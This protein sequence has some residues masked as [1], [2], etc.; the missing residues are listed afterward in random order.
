MP[1]SPPRNAWNCAMSVPAM[2]ALPPAPRN[3]AARSPS[4]LRIRAQA[5]P[6]CSY[7]RHV[8]ALRAA[9]R[10]KITVAISPWRLKR[11]SPSL[12]ALL[13]CDRRS[14]RLRTRSSPDLSYDCAV[15][16]ISL[17]L[18]H[19][20]VQDVGVDLEQRKPLLHSLGLFEHEM[21]I[22]AMLRDAALGR[23]FAADHLATLDVHDL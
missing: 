21:H 20:R 13:R 12:I 22:L 18:A 4:S 23:E 19:A 15:V 17:A 14:P 6:S 5:S 7:M 10:S 1:S 11:T 2:K 3:T 16:Q 8:M 9:G